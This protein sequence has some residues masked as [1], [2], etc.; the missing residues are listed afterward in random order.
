M[1]FALPC[2]LA[3]VVVG[4]AAFVPAP[5][6]VGYITLINESSSTV[7]H[8]YISPCE[9]ESWD[10]DLLDSDEVVAPGEVVEFEVDEGCWDLRAIVE[11][12]LELATFS[13]EVG[14]DE[15]VEWTVYDED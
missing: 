8:V 15:E 10:D 14:E 7:T 13:V 6:G 3:A 12:D 11:N 5:L 1:R 9:E 4:L 2:L